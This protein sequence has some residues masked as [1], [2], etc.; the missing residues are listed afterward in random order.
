M[1]V[2]WSLIFFL[3]NETMSFQ[4]T[5]GF[6]F[7]LEQ[8]PKS[9]LSPPRP[10]RNSDHIILSLAY[11]APATMAFQLFWNRSN[12]FYSGPS[13]WLVLCLE[14]FLTIII[15]LLVSQFISQIK[16]HFFREDM[17]STQSTQ[18]LPSPTPTLSYCP[19]LYFS[20]YRLSVLTL[21]GIFICSSSIS[22]S[23]M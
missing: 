5:N 23:R 2:K 14:L 19:L 22:F 4:N 9:F 15:C 10:Y 16:C 21:Y 6:P 8:I 1:A 17:P 20:S 11:S 7:H 18:P 12:S 3:I 13:I